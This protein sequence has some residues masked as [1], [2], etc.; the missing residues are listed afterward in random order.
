MRVNGVRIRT[1]VAHAYAQ[2]PRA[3]AQA[4][5]TTE[6]APPPKAAHCRTTECAP[7]PKAAHCAQK[8][9]I[10]AACPRS[11]RSGP[12]RHRSRSTWRACTRGCATCTTATSPPTSRSSPRPIRAGSASRRDRRR[13]RLR[14]RRHAT[15]V[16]DP[17]DLEAVRLRARARGPRQAPRVLEADRRRAD[18]R[19]VQLDQPR[20]GDRAAAQPDDQRRRDR[21][22]VA[23]RGRLDRRSAR[24]GCWRC[25]RSTR[26]ARSSIDEAVYRSERDDRPSQPRDRPHAA[27]L[28]DPRPRPGAGRSTST[29]GS[30][31]SWST[32]ATSR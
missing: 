21:G 18:R 6:C 13:P 19:R 4:M 7:P 2:P 12:C 16:H 28:R 20:A 23:G 32:A 14:G 17:V 22:D 10:V 3:Y 8:L 15:A 24:R 26:A 29:S 9:H 31:R 25:S 11:A 30:A 5:R 27:Q 1:A